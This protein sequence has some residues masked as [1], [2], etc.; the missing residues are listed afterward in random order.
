MAGRRGFGARRSRWGMLVTFGSA[1]RAATRPGSAGVGQRLI[2]VPRMIR[3][4]LRGEYAGLT[5]G[6]LAGMLA[7]LAYVLSPV[8]LVPEAVLPLLGVADDAMVVGW[9]AAAL[10]AA[11]EEFLAWERGRPGGMPSRGW[12]SDATATPQDAGSTPWAAGGDTRTVRSF[13]V[14]D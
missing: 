6:A 9:L 11:T 3:A 2:A 8:D 5:G 1:L 14:S 10:V 13:V 4:T 7:A 12:P